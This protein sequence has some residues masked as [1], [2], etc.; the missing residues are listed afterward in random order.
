MDEYLG[1]I[2]PLLFL[3]YS[4]VVA[5]KKARKRHQIVKMNKELQTRLPDKEKGE[6]VMLV[7]ENGSEDCFA[8]YSAVY[9]YPNYLFRTDSRQKWTNEETV[10]CFCVFGG[11]N[12]VYPFSERYVERK[13][14]NERLRRCF[15][16]MA[17]GKSITKKRFFKKIKFFNLWFANQDM[18]IINL[19]FSDEIQAM[20][21]AVM[22]K[23]ASYEKVVPL[24][25]VGHADEEISHIH[26][27]YYVKPEYKKV[28]HIEEILLTVGIQ[29]K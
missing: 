20:T 5:G 11:E 21:M 14:L 22:N 7:L 4:L 26:F 1:L 18:E 8:D 13:Q 25:A 28:P 3:G 29:I 15:I 2:M 10:D 16:E 24:C 17:N 23:L 6:P 9:G 27:L 12:V 19:A